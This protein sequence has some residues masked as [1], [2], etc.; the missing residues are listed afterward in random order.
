M[1]ENSIVSVSDVC[2]FE[3]NQNLA[4]TPTQKRD[5]LTNLTRFS[6]SFLALAKPQTSC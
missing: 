2:T 1:I 3:M 6:Y 5:I 4:T